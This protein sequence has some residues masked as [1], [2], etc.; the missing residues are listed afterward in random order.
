MFL[1]TDS[2]WNMH[3]PRSMLFLPANNSQVLRQASV[4]SGALTRNSPDC[5]TAIIG[6]K[7]RPVF[8]YGNSCGT[9]PHL[10]VRNYKTSHEVFIFASRFPVLIKDQPHDFVTCPS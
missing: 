6:D 9:S 5:A 10:L 7:Q 4:C 8:P 3:P 1:T 2:G